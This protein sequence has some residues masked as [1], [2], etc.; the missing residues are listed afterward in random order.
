MLTCVA[1]APDASRPRVRQLVG[2]VSS[3]TAVSPRATRSGRRAVRAGFL[4]ATIGLLLG[5]CAHGDYAYRGGSMKDP[6]AADMGAAMARRASVLSASEPFKRIAT[7]R[8]ARIAKR[9]AARAVA[10]RTVRPQVVMVKAAAPEAVTSIPAVA[11]PVFAMPADTVT[12]STHRPAAAQIAPQPA[13]PQI[14]APQRAPIERPAVAALPSP[15]KPAPRAGAIDVGQRMIEEGRALMQ[16]GRVLKAREKL[17]AAMIGPAKAR[18]SEVLPELARTYDPNVLAKLP[19][20]DAAPNAAMARALYQ[21]SLMM[22]SPTADADLS[23]LG[24]A[25]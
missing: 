10:A 9:A 13:A 7:A 25:K 22:G 17:Y 16:T 8:K 6:Y 5:G 14:V 15:A 12:M 21:R 18:L 11:A 1:L 20:P 23:R 4:L 24:E 2:S 3:E 19:K